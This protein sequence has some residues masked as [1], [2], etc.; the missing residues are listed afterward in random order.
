MHDH[1]VSSRRICPRIMSQWIL[2]S[3][4][5]SRRYE[6]VLVVC[7]ITHDDDGDL[8]K[9]KTVDDALIQLTL[10]PAPKELFG[11]DAYSLQGL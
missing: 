8:F 1:F 6:H 7:V 2:L 11:A 4:S 10:L 5:T 3:R 9:K